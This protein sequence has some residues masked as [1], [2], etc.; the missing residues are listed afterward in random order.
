M[1]KRYSWGW[2]DG[3]WHIAEYAGINPFEE[4]KHVMC[5]AKPDPNGYIRWR[6]AIPAVSG[7]DELCQDCIEAMP[8]MVLG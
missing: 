8:D 4:Q 7:P 1:M 3:Q 6:K 2:F 5:G